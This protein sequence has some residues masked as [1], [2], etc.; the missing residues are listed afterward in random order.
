MQS[1]GAAPGSSWG[2]GTSV[3][4]SRCKPEGALGHWEVTGLAGQPSC[5]A[6][7]CPADRCPAD[8]HKSGGVVSQHFNCTRVVSG[9]PIYFG[10]NRLNLE[11]IAMGRRKGKK[12][13]DEEDEEDE[14][15][16]ARER[17]KSEK[18]KKRPEVLLRSVR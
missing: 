3:P 16:D 15:M 1:R 10:G 17:E 6:D 4:S 18:D 2:R 9:N 12:D 7:R 11:N 8:R 5:P 13:E 14:S